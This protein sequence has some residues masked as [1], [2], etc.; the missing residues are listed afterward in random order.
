MQQKVS[1]EQYR[2][3]IVGH[4]GKQII[5][6]CQNANC[7]QTSRR[8]CFLCQQ[9]HY[10]DPQFHPS[11]IKEEKGLQGEIEEQKIK[12]AATVN[13]IQLHCDIQNYLLQLEMIQ[14]IQQ[15]SQ[16]QQILQDISK[17]LDKFQQENL[18]QISVESYIE[19]NNKLG[20]KEYIKSIELKLIEINQ[21]KNSYLISTANKQITQENIISV[22]QKSIQQDLQD[23]LQYRNKLKERTLQQIFENESFQQVQIQD[24]PYVRLCETL[25]KQGQDLK[26]NLYDQYQQLRKTVLPSHIEQYQ[27]FYLDA[28]ALYNSQDKYKTIDQQLNLI[29]K[30]LEANQDYQKSHELKQLILKPT[31]DQVAS[32]RAIALANEAIILIQS[33]QFQEAL[34]L[35]DQAISL[36]PDFQQAYYIQG[37]CYYNLQKHDQAV[38]V[39]NSAIALDPNDVQSIMKKAQSLEKLDRLVE[40]LN[41]IQKADEL[42]PNNVEVYKIRATT[43]KKLNRLEEALVDYDR[44]IQVE[45]TNPTTYNNKGV[46]LAQLE[47]YQEA[48]EMFD[49]AIEYN[50]QTY[51]FFENKG[52]FIY[53]FFIGKSLQNLQK[54]EESLASFDEAIILNP[55]NESIY[56]LKARSLVQLGKD[57]EAKDLLKNFYEENPN[58][59]PE[60]QE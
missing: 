30:S 57:Q 47:R 59:Q 20:I 37:L 34:N 23:T 39:F 50:P 2:C 5:G 15:W 40:L 31:Y 11:D 25:L 24:S 38:Q 17:E 9:L 60:E 32:Q 3:N 56:K 8:V 21:I 14:F 36:K 19:N 43:L 22:D 13:D 12:L 29:D 1:L 28:Y 49:K 16:K 46:L 54:Y 10:M 6:M 4:E 18:N 26:I 51:N 42:T 33:N 48:V 52:V 45:P 35:L 44:A 41:T 7:S 58:I 27:L 53:I 55:K